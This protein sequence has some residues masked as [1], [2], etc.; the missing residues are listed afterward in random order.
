MCTLER[1]KFKVI[2]E[3]IT[4]SKVKPPWVVSKEPFASSRYPLQA[5]KSQRTLLIAKISASQT[6]QSPSLRVVCLVV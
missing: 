1:G 6:S 3:N 2:S 4:F 5:L